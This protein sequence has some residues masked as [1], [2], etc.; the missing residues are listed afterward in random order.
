M[1]GTL[2]TVAVMTSA[3]AAIGLAAVAARYGSAPAGRTAAEPTVLAAGPRGAGEAGGQPAAAVP[4]DLYLRRLQG[5]PADVRIEVGSGRPAPVAGLETVPVTLSRDTQTQR[6]DLLRSTDGRYLL[7]GPLLDMGQDPHA[8]VA[9]RLDLRE[10]P[11]LGPSDAAVTVVEY[12]SFQCP[13]CRKLAPAVKHTMQGPLGKQVRWVY[14]HFPLSTQAW[15]EL[16]AVGAECARRLGG[17]GRFWAIHEFYFEQQDGLTPQN[18]RE[19][20]VA[21]TKT[22]GLSVGRFEQCLDSPEALAR[23]REDVDEGRRIGVSSTPTLVINGRLA[24]GAVSREVLE[25]TLQQELT[26]QRARA[27]AR[28]GK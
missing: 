18:H 24:P 4:L 28:E 26:Y 13:Y 22:A 9:S 14:K 27:R 17:D 7:P 6:L 12:S 1:N 3:A 15:S 10:R 23:V 11:S 20:A 19:R 21:W 8:A 2:L 16:A 5:I 25:A